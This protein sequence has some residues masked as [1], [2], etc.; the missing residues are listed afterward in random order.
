MYEQYPSRTLCLPLLRNITRF[1]ECSARMIDSRSK[2]VTKR[3][4]IHF[5]PRH[6]QRV[7]V[8]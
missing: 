1:L 3:R 6:V 5:I 2:N 7:G 8:M 4:L